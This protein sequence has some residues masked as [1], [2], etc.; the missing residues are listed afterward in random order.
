MEGRFLHFHARNPEAYGVTDR[1]IFVADSFAG[2]PPP[3]ERQYPLDKGDVH[4]TA[5]LLAVSKEEVEGNFRKY[6]LMDDQVIF[7]KG[8]FK[9][10][11]RKPP[12]KS[13][14][15]SDLTVTCMVQPLRR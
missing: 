9:D 12:L 13:S 11:L 15:Y 14:Q 4:H 8:W 5:P 2:L 10:T 3:D 1:R 6:G 7:L